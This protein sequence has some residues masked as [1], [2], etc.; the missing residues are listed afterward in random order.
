MD[1]LKYSII[2]HLANIRFGD[3]GYIF[4]VTYDG[5]SLFSNGKI[6][7]GSDN[8]WDLTDPAGVKIIQE[9]KRIIDTEGEG[10]LEYQWNKLEDENLY[11]KI[12]YITGIPQWKWIIGAGIYLDNIESLIA[13]EKLILRQ[14][15]NN[16]IMKLVALLAF[17]IVIIANTSIYV[18][19]RLK[20]NFKTF[21]SFFQKAENEN[22]QIEP[23][24]VHFSEFQSIAHSANSLI[25]KRTQAEENLRLFR[26]VFYYSTDGIEII[27]PD[28]T[29]YEQ[30]P[31][32]RKL[33]GYSNEDLA[34]KTPAVYMGDDNFHEMKDALLEYEFYRAETYMRTSD[35]RE[36]FID[37]SSF[38][39]F[40]KDGNVLFYVAIQ[41]DN[42]EQKAI[43]N[44]LQKSEEKY[45]NLIETMEEGM[46]LVDADENILFANQATGIIFD[47]PYE[48]L[49]GTNLKNVTLKDDIEHLLFQTQRRKEGIR[50][51]YEIRCQT[52][53]GA[54]KFLLVNARPIFEEDEY[55]G[56]FSVFTDIT[57]IKK[58]QHEL[59][60]SLAEKVVMLQEIHHRVKNNMQIIISLLHLQSMYID[61]EEIVSR[62]KVIENR[63]RSM[64]IIHEKLY[65]SENFVDIDFGE[66]IEELF[67][68]LFNSTG[69]ADEKIQCK[70]EIEPITL[71]LNQAVPCGLLCNELL[72]N[73]FKHAF[74]GD[75][76]GTVRISMKKTKDGKNKLTIEDDGVGFTEKLEEAGQSSLGLQLIQDLVTQLGGTLSLNKNKG[77]SYTIIF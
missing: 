46:M 77:T 24:E 76:T 55:A 16:H 17:I 21:V 36:V 18:T 10:Y 56:S 72:T 47:I 40:D 41:R 1:E 69:L 58:S 44:E 45:R 60:K 43:F 38:P 63:I 50:D 52:Y 15:I 6:T 37:M 62:F 26:E 59:E 32:H 28:F 7:L 65:E 74:P 71:D 14:R 20:R 70:L 31:T 12:S 51:R 42:T 68:T 11:P 2:E 8:I 27:K 75:M 22:V 9:E 67:R 25:A 35:N 23:E 30:N 64:A 33:F 39:I 29:F 4:G 73:I 3:D 34:G 57:D 19:V 61:D 53:T 5:E 49:I 13:Q 48:E 66:Y 54:I